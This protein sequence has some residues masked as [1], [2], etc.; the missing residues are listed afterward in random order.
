M[1]QG[2]TKQPRECFPRLLCRQTSTG[3]HQAPSQAHKEPC[4][5]SLPSA[6]PQPWEL[7][8]MSIQALPRARLGTRIWGVVLDAALAPPPAP[9]PRVCQGLT[10]CSMQTTHS[11]FFSSHCSSGAVGTTGLGGSLKGA[12]GSGAAGTSASTVFSSSA[13]T[14]RRSEH[15][16]SCPSPTH[17]ARMGMAAG[18]WE[19]GAPINRKMDGTSLMVQPELCQ[20]SLPC[21]SYHAPALHG[22]A[23]QREASGPV[24]LPV[25]GSGTCCEYTRCQ[26]PDRKELVVP[27]IVLATA[28]IS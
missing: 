7:G 18:R 21:L 12:L 11:D 26:K 16:E 9:A 17:P 6:M 23:P 13:T 10:S 1:G 14:S 24:D 5:A 3:A 27:G 2:W 22:S 4:P 8:G 20:G 28:R 15:Q 25:Q 19:L